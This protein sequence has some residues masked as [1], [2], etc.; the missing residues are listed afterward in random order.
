VTERLVATS[1]RLERERQVVVRGGEPGI[2][3]QRVAVLRDGF[4]ESAPRGEE[5]AEVVLTSAES[6]SSAAAVS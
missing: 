1:E 5:E 3:P 2:D 4:L 6:G